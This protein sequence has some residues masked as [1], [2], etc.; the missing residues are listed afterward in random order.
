MGFLK[1]YK[2]YF[3]IIFVGIFCLQ[4]L[5]FLLQLSPQTIIYPDSYNYLESAQNL[6]QELELHYYRPVLMAFLTGFPY[7]F[8]SSDS[9]IFQWSFIINIFC[10]LGTAILIFEMLKGFVKEG[11]A[12]CFAILS[13]FIVGNTALNFHLLT[14]NIF[15]FSITVAFYFLFRYYKSDKFSHLSLSLSLFLITM[16]IKPGAKF[17]AIMLC[18]FFIRELIKNYKNKSSLF[19]YGSVLIIAVQL[20][21]MRNQYGDY[22]ISYIDGVTCHNYI[23]SK[24]DCYKSGREYSQINNPRAEYLFSLSFPEQ[25]IAASEDLK[26]QLKTNFPNMLKAYFSDVAENSKSG[27]GCIEGL[28]NKEN[29]KG[30]ESLKMFFFNIT[31]WQNRI[32]TVIGILLSLTFLAKTYRKPN[33][34][35]FISIFILYTI[36]LSGVSCGQGDRFHLVTFPFTV[37]LLGVILSKTKRSSERPQK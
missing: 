26:K 7:L 18:L 19:I 2:Y 32:F 34:L 27:N 11:T 5:N 16:L 24:A 12:F 1:K 23:C 13:F 22:T 36:V 28:E 14:E 35:T 4:T 25:K 29:S 33:L 9:G 37:L 6:Y 31:K 17:F 8:G 3:L 15:I 30:F 20:I 10:W 21:G